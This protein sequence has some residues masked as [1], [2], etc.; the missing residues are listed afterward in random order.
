M[1]P[2]RLAVPSDVRDATVTRHPLFGARTSQSTSFDFDYLISP[3]RSWAGSPRV[4]VSVT[5]PDAWGAPE[6][7]VKD[8]GAAS[9][10]VVTG[11]DFVLESSVSERLSIRVTLPRPRFFAGGLMVGLA[12]PCWRRQG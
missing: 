2:G 6:V 4:S 3:L 7:T 5:T 10:R 9:P 11:P 8:T 1:I 12:A